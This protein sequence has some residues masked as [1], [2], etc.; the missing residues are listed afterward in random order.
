MSE[1]ESDVPPRRV[2]SCSTSMRRDVGIG[3]HERQ[4]AGGVE[5]RL[6]IAGERRV[7]GGAELGDC[8]GRRRRDGEVDG[9]VDGAVVVAQRE[10]ERLAGGEAVQ[11]CA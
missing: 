9:A 1:K 3:G 8:A 6:T 11:V 2:V 10:A 4:A 5:L 7:D